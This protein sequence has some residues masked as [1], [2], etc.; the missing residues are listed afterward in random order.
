[1]GLL[2]GGERELPYRAMCASIERISTWPV[3]LP[4]LTL[5]P[6]QS[7]ENL[8]PFTKDFCVSE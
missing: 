4:Q 8:S 6:E 1:M 7:Q 3:R 5:I 2:K